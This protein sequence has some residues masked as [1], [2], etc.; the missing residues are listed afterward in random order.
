MPKYEPIQV[1]LESV[2]RPHHRGV[3]RILPRLDLGRIVHFGDPDALMPD[4][5]DRGDGRTGGTR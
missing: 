1:I 5:G 4:Y 2:P 3:E